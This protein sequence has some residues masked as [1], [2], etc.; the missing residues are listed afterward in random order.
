M[1]KLT[2]RLAGQLRDD[3]LLHLAVLL[4]HKLLDE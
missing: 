4:A 2:V 1:T 3:A